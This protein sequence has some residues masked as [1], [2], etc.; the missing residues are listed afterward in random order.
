ML[1]SDLLLLRRARGTI[2][3]VY[4]PFNDD[5]RELAEEMIKTVEHSIGRKR[6]EIEEELEKFEE[7]GFN[8][9]FVRG[10]AT[11][12]LRNCEF[13][14]NATLADDPRHLRKRVFLAA[15]PFVLTKEER[16]AVLEEVAKS[17]DTSSETLEEN[18]WADQEAELL[19]KKF[20]KPNPDALL[21]LYNL[22][23]T[24]TLISKA[25]RLTLT[26][27]SEWKSLLW[28]VKKR[29]LMYR[30]QMMNGAFLLD[31]ESPVSLTNGGGV[32][33]DLLVDLFHE[34]LR[35][36]Q[37]K[38]LAEVRKGGSPPYVFE[39]ENERARELGLAPSATG[40]RKPSFDSEIERKFYYAFSS[41]NTGWTIKREE[42]PVI[43]GDSILLPD[44]SLEKNGS[45]VYLEIVGYWT[46]DYLERKVKKLHAVTGTP[47]IIL[48]DKKLSG[49]AKLAEIPGVIFFEK[50]LGLNKVLAELG[51]YEKTEYDLPELKDI[52]ELGALEREARE[53]AKRVLEEKGYVIT[54]ATAVSRRVLDAVAQRLREKD[55]PTYEDAERLCAE[56]HLN[57][58]DVL[59]I[60]GFRVVWRG[61]E[62]RIE[63]KAS[64]VNT[65]R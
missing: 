30:A 18:L 45:K 6:G 60:L 20:A 9:K 37:W 28:S 21:R 63:T 49:E 29:G 24:E 61:L 58:P 22:E 8:F 7:L 43:A 57:T 41:I 25:S 16:E 13:G 11:L 1:P 39:L 12:I 59:R 27:I 38:V 17:L 50:E 33:G 14:V 3:P 42:S 44:F 26:R 36:S 51:K 35:Y 19:L 53:K 52:I 48:A 34:I 65:D 5:T 46:R 47:I 62:P 31:I 15:S 54:G 40:A 10:L 2:T 55:S 32:Y 64:A 4:A 23:L 56:F